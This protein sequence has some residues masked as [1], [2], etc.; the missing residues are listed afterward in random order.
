MNDVAAAPD[1][2]TLLGTR[3]SEEGCDDRRCSLRSG[4]QRVP[5]AGGKLTPS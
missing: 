3:Q 2:R 4:C 5:L 1:R